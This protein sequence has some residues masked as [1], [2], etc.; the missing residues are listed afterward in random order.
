MKTRLPL[1][2]VKSAVTLDGKIAAPQ[3]NEGWITS[4]TAR[5]HVQL[6]RHHADAILTGI[7]TVLNDDCLLTDRSGLQRSRPLLRIVLDSQLRIPAQFENGE[8]AQRRSAHWSAHQPLR[9]NGKRA[10][11]SRGVRVL[12]A[13]D[14]RGRTDI[15][16][17]VAHLAT[18]TLSFADG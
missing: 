5:A 9:R 14:P 12:I 8:S 7:G 2:T 6:L 18:R 3:N 15:K 1:V 10:L 16:A 11:E 17:V 4:E 13:D